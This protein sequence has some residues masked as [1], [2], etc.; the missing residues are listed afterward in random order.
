MVCPKVKGDH[1]RLLTQ[2]I[3]ST[4]EMAEKK[5]P[6]PAEGF[7]VKAELRMTPDNGIGVFA[8]EAIPAKAVVY[9]CEPDA[10][11]EEEATAHLDS[12]PTREDRIDWLDHA[13]GSQGKVC[14]DPGDIVRVNHSDTPT[15]ISELSPDSTPRAIKNVSSAA[16]DISVG[17]ELTED[18]R[19]Y[20][21]ARAYV[22]LCNKYGLK[23]VYEMEGYVK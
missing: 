23:E 8:M 7:A 18:Y 17:E 21:I 22:N 11:T 2:Q 16:R 14:I 10:Y 20:S 6:R 3:A 19:T 13:Y 12:L 15:L 4:C 1:Q 9:E 5:L